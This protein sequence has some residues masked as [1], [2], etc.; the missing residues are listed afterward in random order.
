MKEDTM[1]KRFRYRLLQLRF[2]LDNI[3]LAIVEARA[4]YA[5]VNALSENAFVSKTEH[6]RRASELLEA[7]SKG[8]AERRELVSAL[9]DANAIIDQQEARLAFAKATGA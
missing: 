3:V 1:L 4:T 7:N 6:D 8:V 2:V 5:F 9:R